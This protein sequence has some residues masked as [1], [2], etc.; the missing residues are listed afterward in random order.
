MSEWLRNHY[1]AGVEVRAIGTG[2]KSGTI[3]EHSQRA[4]CGVYVEDKH[5]RTNNWNVVDC[6][7]CLTLREGTKK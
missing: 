3:T 6:K 2:S 5:H 7:R 1:C 4:L